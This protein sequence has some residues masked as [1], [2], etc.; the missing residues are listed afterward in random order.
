MTHHGN[1]D[2][3]QLRQYEKQLDLASAIA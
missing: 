1:L 2:D 3:S